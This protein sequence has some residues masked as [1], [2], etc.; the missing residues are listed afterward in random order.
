MC[1][2]KGWGTTPDLGLFGRSVR[3]LQQRD[4]VVLQRS[5]RS[6]KRSESVTVRNEMVLTDE[7]KERQHQTSVTVVSIYSKYFYPSFE[8]ATVIQTQLLKKT[9]V[10][11]LT[12]SSQKWLLHRFLVNV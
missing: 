8:K 1:G 7:Q 4:L 9:S 5:L 10:F 2:G 3:G 12:C 11:T 6:V